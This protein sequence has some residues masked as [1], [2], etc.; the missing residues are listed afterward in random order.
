MLSWAR[1]VKMEQAKFTDE[2]LNEL[3]DLVEAAESRSQLERIR[4][5]LE[6]MLKHSRKKG[7]Q[8]SRPPLPKHCNETFKPPNAEP[9]GPAR[10][11]A[12]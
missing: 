9:S 10:S 11:E 4:S 5:R 6:A 3:R 7:L 2:E 12:K 1:E 8:R